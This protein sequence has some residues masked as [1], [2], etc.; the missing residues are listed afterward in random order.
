[1]KTKI[2]KW[3]QPFVISTKT[4]MWNNEEHE[5][6]IV[7]EEFS[8]NAGG[9][10]MFTICIAGVLAVSDTYP[11]EY[12]ELGLIHELI[13][14]SP[15]DS[16]PCPLALHDELQLAESRGMNMEKYTSFRLRFFSD[17]ILYYE[18]KERTESEDSLLQQLKESRELLAKTAK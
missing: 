11:E 9:P 8:L 14:Y 10:R 16:K 6:A 17:L 1:M 4:F 5:Y 7:S 18:G 13:E 12:R 2:P 15:T 3:L